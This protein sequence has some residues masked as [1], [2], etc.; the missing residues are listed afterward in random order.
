MQTQLI[1]S[2]VGTLVL[3]LMPQTFRHISPRTFVHCLHALFVNT[4]VLTDNVV[5]LHLHIAEHDESHDDIPILLSQFQL[6]LRSQGVA[7]QRQVA[8]LSGTPLQPQE[9]A[10]YADVW[11]I[12]DI[13][14]TPRS[15]AQLRNATDL[16]ARLYEL[17][18]PT[19][20]TQSDQ[21]TSFYLLAEHLVALNEYCL[22]LEHAHCASYRQ[23]SF[24][25][26]N[27]LDA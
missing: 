15:L 12:T 4:K 9:W 25:Q 24:Q 5:S 16:L 18:L 20:A 7:L 11:Q 17:M 23:L 1:R 13:S 6:E 2:E 19:A 21:A 3:P 8:F 27:F 10:C 14:D 26:L 22:A